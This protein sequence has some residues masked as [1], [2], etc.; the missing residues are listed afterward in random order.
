MIECT[1]DISFKPFNACFFPFVSWQLQ[2]D[3]GINF[4]IFFQ[5][6]P[7]ELRANPLYYRVYYVHL[8]TI[9]ASVIPLI[10]LVSSYFCKIINLLGNSRTLFSFLFTFSIQLREVAQKLP[11]TGFEPQISDVVSY[12]STNRATTIAHVE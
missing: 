1:N 8:N 4:V 12:R 5:V 9:F 3:S 11:L 6:I 2:P 7:T 10:S